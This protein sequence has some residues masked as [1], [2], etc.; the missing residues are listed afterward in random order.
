[1]KHVIITLILIISLAIFGSGVG[2]GLLVAMKL[3]DVSRNTAVMT[4]A[5][6]TYPT[7]QEV[8]N[9]LQRYRVKNG[10]PEFQLSEILCDNLVERW[11]NYKKTNSHEGLEEFV[12]R[13]YP[14]NLVVHEIMVSGSTAEEM[15]VKWS[16]SP[17]HNQAIHNNSK[18]CVYSSQG[19]AVAMLSN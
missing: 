19:M 18:I 12:K 14:P 13:E 3:D 8:L 17:G 10:L 4:P 15:V 5:P 6:T 9:E 1:M 7:G 2:I 11:Q 16:Q